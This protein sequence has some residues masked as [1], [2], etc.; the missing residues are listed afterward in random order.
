MIVFSLVVTCMGIAYE[1]TSHLSPFFTSNKNNA[2]VSLKVADKLYM[3]GSEHMIK[4]IRNWFR[5][6][7]NKKTER[8]QKVLEVLE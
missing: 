5:V 6:S 8:M 1:L 3:K 7:T 4:R 2:K